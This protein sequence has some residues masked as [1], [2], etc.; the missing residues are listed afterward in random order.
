MFAT[1]EASVIV[2]V[3]RCPGGRLSNLVI[4]VS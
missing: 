2:G 3:L 1:N 4:V